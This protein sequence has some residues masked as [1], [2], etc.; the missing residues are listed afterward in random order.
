VAS[1]PLRECLRDAARRLNRPPRLALRE[2][3]E[4]VEYFIDSYGLGTLIAALRG[5]GL[6][7][8]GTGTLLRA[9]EGTV[10]GESLLLFVFTNNEGIHRYLNIVFRSILV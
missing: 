9:S 3:D 2:I 7:F 1:A 6:H 10:S 8:A 4:D 5:A